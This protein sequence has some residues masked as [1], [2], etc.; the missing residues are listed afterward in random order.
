MNFEQALNQ[1]LKENGG[2]DK[3]S[4]AGK[5]YSAL[6][7]KPRF[8][9]LRKATLKFAEARVAHEYERATGRTFSSWGDGAILKWLAENIGPWLKII[10][11]LILAM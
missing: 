5:A 3:R 10:L 7:A 11:P 6:N 2:D 9:R 4:N 1:V 8:P